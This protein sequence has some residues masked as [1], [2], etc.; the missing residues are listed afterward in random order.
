MQVFADIGEHLLRTTQNRFGN[1]D[2]PPGKPWVPP[3]QG[4][5]SPNAHY[6]DPSPAPEGFSC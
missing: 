1:M 6:G 5:E 3:S 2:D 4:N